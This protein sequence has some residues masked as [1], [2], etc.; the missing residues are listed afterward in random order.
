MRHALLTFFFVVGRIQ[1]GS[2]QGV[3]SS[4]FDKFGFCK[5]II[6]AWDDF[7]SKLGGHTRF[8]LIVPK[9]NN[10]SKSQTVFNMVGQCLAASSLLMLFSYYYFFVRGNSRFRGGIV[11]MTGCGGTGRHRFV[12][13]QEVSA[14]VQLISCGEIVNGSGRILAEHGQ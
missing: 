8:A 5:E 10:V 2:R 12:H 13:F 4:D 1:P 7:F 6:G 3:L 14:T 9:Q 11:A